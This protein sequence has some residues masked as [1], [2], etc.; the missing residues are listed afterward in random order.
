MIEFP[1]LPLPVPYDENLEYTPT[2]WNIGYL[3]W[4][5]VVHGPGIS[6]GSGRQDLVLAHHQLSSN[7]VIVKATVTTE[8][9]PEEEEE[10]EPGPKTLPDTGASE[11]AQT[12]GLVGALAVMF[13]GALVSDQP[14]AGAKIP[15]VTRS[16]LRAAPQPET[17]TSFRSRAVA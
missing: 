9:K 4:D 13:G 2:L 14:S 6:S 11:S 16:R 7:E 17:W 12:M 5:E 10:P 8:L 3:D 1:S 15:Q